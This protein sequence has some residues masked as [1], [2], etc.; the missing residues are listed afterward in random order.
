MN[1]FKALTRPEFLYRPAQIYSRLKYAFGPPTGECLVTM[2][3]GHAL[4][5]DAGELHG[6]ALL[7]HGVV[8]LALTEIIWRL[9]DEGDVAVDIGANIGS[10]TSAMVHR[11]GHRGTVIAFEPH[12][13]TRAR[14][15]T[16]VERWQTRGCASVTVREE[17][18]SSHVGKAFLSEP[19]GFQANSGLAR[20]DQNSDGIEVKTTTFDQVFAAFATVNLV[21]IDVEGNEAQVLAGM[22]SSLQEGK[23]NHLIFEDFNHLPSSNC[24][25]V[26]NFG[27]TTFLIRRTIRGPAFIST[28]EHPVAAPGDPPNVFATLHPDV[29]HEKL[30]AHGYRC[31][32]H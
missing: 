14:L 27:Y 23:I 11:V 25:T 12:P 30:L 13:T 2:P 4:A 28:R 31:L 8:D 5:V 1:P 10:L 22:T 19:K 3:W 7:T 18:V 16:N 15:N 6:R 26:E 20:I 29:V 32:V 17:A 21:K 24:L 9:L